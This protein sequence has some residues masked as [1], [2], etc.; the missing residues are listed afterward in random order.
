MRLC[1]KRVFLDEE[2]GVRR[3]ESKDG[4]FLVKS[5]YKPLESNS[6]IYIPMKI[7]WNR[8][9]LVSLLGKLHEEKF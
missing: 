8:Q 4:N 6:S 2:D 3:L 9:K 5:L 1:G 7:I